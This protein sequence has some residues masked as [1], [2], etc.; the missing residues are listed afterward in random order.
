MPSQRSVSPNVFRA[1]TST[2][3]TDERILSDMPA[4]LILRL[5]RARPGVN[6]L[7]GRTGRFLGE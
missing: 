5:A 6:C 1:A 7:F 4:T 3:Y 2:S